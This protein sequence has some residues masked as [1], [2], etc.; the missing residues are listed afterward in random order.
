MREFLI[1]SVCSVCFFCRQYFFTFRGRE[2]ER[3]TERIPKEN[4][5]E[6]M[7]CFVQSGMW[8]AGGREKEIQETKVERDVGKLEQKNTFCV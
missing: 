4:E 2:R 5:E 6:D 3:E 8:S 1:N 7:V